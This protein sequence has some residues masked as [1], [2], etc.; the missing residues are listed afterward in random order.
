MKLLCYILLLFPVL[1]IGQEGG[2]VN[3]LSYDYD[4]THVTNENDGCITIYPNGSGNYT[5]TWYNQFDSVLGNEQAIKSLSV[6]VYKVTVRDSVM[7]PA[8]SGGAL[9]VSVANAYFWVGKYGETTTLSFQPNAK[10]GEDAFI[11]LHTNP[12]LNGENTN[13]GDRTNIVARTGTNSGAPN[14]LRFLMRFQYNGLKD[15]VVDSVLLDLY[16]YQYRNQ[17]QNTLEP[18]VNNELYVRRVD[19]GQLWN[20][21]TVTWNSNIFATTNNQV[22][23]DRI[24]GN[25]DFITN[26]QYLKNIDITNLAVNQIDESHE[27]NGFLVSLVEEFRYRYQGFYSSDFTDSTKHPRIT[28]KF[29]VPND[30]EK[31]VCAIDS[32]LPC[33]TCIGSFAPIPEGKYLIGAWT[34]Q[35]NASRNDSVYDDAQLSIVCQTSTGAV[36]L[37]PYIPS[38]EIIDEWQRIEEEFTIPSGTTN[39]QI[40]LAS[41]SGDVYFDDIRMFPF[42]ASMKSYVYDPINMRLS[43]ELDERHYATFYEYDEEGKLVRIKKETER[44]V[45]TIQETKSNSAK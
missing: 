12:N 25:Y 28:I 45:M 15:A 39:I 18:Q 30:V 21:N 34:R 37:G 27:N 43:A 42:N 20:E 24:G 13:Y 3:E 16:G 19:N 22:V 7:L 40:V 41:T 6:G 38:G 8:S 11:V 44:G 14:F 26:L 5:Y 1:A 36:T 31:I 9:L 33:E 2:F 23:V 35:A 32:I 17:P 10:F 4:L 29:N